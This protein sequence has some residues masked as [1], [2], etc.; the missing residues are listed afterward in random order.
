L[1]R[2]PR[3]GKKLNELAAALREEGLAVA[4]VSERLLE[5]W[6]QNPELAEAGRLLSFVLRYQ[7]AA[8]NRRADKLEREGGGDE[9]EA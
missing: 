8:L 7:V 9:D 3:S 5:D 6:T 1:L 4:E 2:L